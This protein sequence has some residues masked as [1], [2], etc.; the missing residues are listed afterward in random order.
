MIVHFCISLVKWS[1]I[2]SM[3]LSIVKIVN[4]RWIYSFININSNILHQVLQE[5]TSQIISTINHANVG[6]IHTR[7]TRVEI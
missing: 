1:L 4:V 7:S 5:P 2:K 6:A 3:E